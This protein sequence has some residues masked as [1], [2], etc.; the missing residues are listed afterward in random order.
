MFRD[1]SGLAPIIPTVRHRRRVVKEETKIAIDDDTKYD[2]QTELDRLWVA[3]TKRE[4]EHPNEHPQRRAQA[5]IEETQASLCRLAEIVD[6]R[7]FDSIESAA[8]PLS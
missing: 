3:A 6:T 2:I 8:P 7:A 1:G 5:Q 4:R